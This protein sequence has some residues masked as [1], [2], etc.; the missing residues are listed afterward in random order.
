[1]TQDKQKLK[2]VET[3]PNVTLIIININGLKS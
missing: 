1:M 3:S 2:I